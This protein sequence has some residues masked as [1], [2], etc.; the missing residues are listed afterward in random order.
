MDVAHTGQQNHSIFSF[1][2]LSNNFDGQY[3][4][5]SKV[6]DEFLCKNG[7]NIIKIYFSWD[8]KYK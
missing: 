2:I 7:L 3:T 1:E 5:I 8:G 6:E 4:D